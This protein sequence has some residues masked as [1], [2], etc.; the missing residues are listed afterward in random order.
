MLHT[1]F[2]ALLVFMTIPC[3]DAQPSLG[4]GVTTDDNTVSA[5]SY[6]N[7]V[8]WFDKNSVSIYRYRDKYGLIREDGTIII[9][10]IYDEILCAKRIGLNSSREYGCY[11]VKKNGYSGCVTIDG[12]LVMHKPEWNTDGNC[13]FSGDTMIVENT[14]THQSNMVNY[15]GNL[16]FETWWDLMIPIPNGGGIAK[17]GDLYS[18]VDKK[19]TITSTFEW[20]G[21]VTYLEDYLILSNQQ[22]SIWKLM[23]IKDSFSLDNNSYEF[24]DFNGFS[25]NLLVFKQ[26]GKY[27]FLDRAGDKAI[28]NIFDDAYAFSNGAAKVCIGNQQGFIDKKGNALFMVSNDNIE[29]N[30]VFGVNAVK[31]IEKDGTWGFIDRTGKVLCRIQPETVGYPNSL[32]YEEMFPAYYKNRS[33]GYMNIEGKWIIEPQWQRAYAFVGKYAYVQDQSGLFG[34]INRDGHYTINPQWGNV[35][36]IILKNNKA[37]FVVKR[38]TDKCDWIV[39]NEEGL[40]VSYY[41]W[42]D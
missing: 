39:V 24:L 13:Y 27:G 9:E 11:V 7:E 22:G 19:G 12:R 3:Y 25:E 35:K 26:N 6:M 42:N 18:F 17:K 14:K 21:I 4:N 16:L 20:K 30:D 28:E 23:D 41:F 34:V 31:Y 37:Y 40:F 36:D 2:V 8:G 32:S 10:P 1:L 29:L 38:T 5:N 33:F 15:E